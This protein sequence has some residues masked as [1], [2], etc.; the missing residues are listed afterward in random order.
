[1]SHK[2]LIRDEFIPKYCYLEPLFRQKKALIV[3][4]VSFE[5]SIS[6]LG[7]NIV[8]KSHLYYRNEVLFLMGNYCIITFFDFSN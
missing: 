8:L 1:M 3:L 7:F 2:S 4:N 5:S 6:P